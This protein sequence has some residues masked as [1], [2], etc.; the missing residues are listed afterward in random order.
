M[1]WVDAVGLGDDLGEGAAVIR[2]CSSMEEKTHASDKA[3]LGSHA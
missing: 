1:A 2:A 3:P